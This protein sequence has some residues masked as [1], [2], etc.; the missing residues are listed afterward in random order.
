ML[1]TALTE[2]RDGGRRIALV[3]GDSAAGKSRS[4][5]EALRR[6]R[7]LR[8]WRLVVPLSDGGLAHLAEADLGWRD[9]VLWLDDL[10]KYLAR[11]LDL[12]TLR[13]VLGD[14]PTVVV[15]ATMRTSQLQARQSQLTDPAWGFLTDKSEVTRVDLEASLS[16]DELQAASNEI[17]DAALLS[18][19]YEGTGLGE[20]LVAG[21]EL[22]KK[23]NDERGLNRAFADIVIAWYRTGLN[24]PLAREAARRLWTDTLPPGLRQ[25]L[26]RRD[27]GEQSQLFEQASVWACEPVLSPNS[28]NK[29][30]SPKRATG[31]SP[32]TTS[33]TRLCEIPSAPWFPTQFGNTPSKLPPTIP[34][35]TRS[36]DSC[37]LSE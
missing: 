28:T 30:S 32:T 6:D 22:M 16:D 8:G 12:G 14:D 18:A 13:R 15:V 20:W 11:G 10:D 25:R 1:D 33:W 9:T 24:Q 2:A 26:T 29:L 4:A 5:A 7:V 17:S 3:T 35:P 19:L 23:L 27:P 31:M 34:T 36:R 37:G 21:P